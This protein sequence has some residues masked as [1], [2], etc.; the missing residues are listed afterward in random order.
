MKNIIS[1]SDYEAIPT[2][3]A[4]NNPMELYYPV[5]IR[6]YE[7]V[8]KWNDEFK[9]NSTLDSLNAKADFQIDVSISHTA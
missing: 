5:R 7:A 3:F 1:E 2:N 4:D 9:W 8:V 6:N